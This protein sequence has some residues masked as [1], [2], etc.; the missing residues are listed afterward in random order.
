MP[1]YRANA[2]VPRHR[3][4]KSCESKDLL[5][6]LEE[7]TRDFGPKGKGLAV[8]WAKKMQAQHGRGA[9]V[10]LEP[11]ASEQL[12]AGGGVDSQ[13]IWNADDP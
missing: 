12:R 1:T 4:D 9:T 11:T 5:E 3:C 10:E 13:T 7:H 8:A 2:W 6:C